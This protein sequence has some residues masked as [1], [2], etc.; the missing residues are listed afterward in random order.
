[1]SNIF[2][3]VRSL[4]VTNGYRVLCADCYREGFCEHDPATHLH[5]VIYHGV[6]DSCG[7]DVALTRRK[8]E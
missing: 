2:S 4:I 1:M 5:A 6:C 8:N 7:L 3:E